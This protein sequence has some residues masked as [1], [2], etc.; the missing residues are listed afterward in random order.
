MT[1]EK[2]K[3]HSALKEAICAFKQEN[4]SIKKESSN[5]FFKSKYADLPT[6]LDAIEVKA[7]T[8]GLVITSASK[9][10]GE[11]WV[12]ETTLEHKE[13]DESKVS[14]FPIHGTKPQEFGSSITY[15]RRYNI[16]SLLNL[17]A[18]DDDGNAANAAPQ[19]FKTARER[20]ALFN[21]ILKELDG[22]ESLDD[23]VEVWTVRK[24]DIAKLRQSDEQIY[25]DLERRKDNLKASFSVMQKEGK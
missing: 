19:L 6:I 10:I 14:L 21:E 18:D 8:H 25:V 9:L 15:A 1:Q 7:A 3:I 2:N 23:L 13:S 4:I 11:S 24:A 20:T 5:P 16:Q 12:L 17:A 22:T